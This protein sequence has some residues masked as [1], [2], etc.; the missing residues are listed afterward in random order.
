MTVEHTRSIPTPREAKA[1]VRKRYKDGGAGCEISAVYPD[2]D[3]V[4][5]PV[6]ARRRRGGRAG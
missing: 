4:W 2:H 1:F 6:E 3:N 5:H